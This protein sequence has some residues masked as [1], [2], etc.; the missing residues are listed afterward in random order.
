MH[1]TR[2]Y[3]LVK[4]HEIQPNTI[5]GAR[6]GGN[7]YSAVSINV[8]SMVTV[9]FASRYVIKLRPALSHGGTKAGTRVGIAGAQGNSRRV[10]GL[11][12]AVAG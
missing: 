10:L 12:G 5:T 4:T 3:M 11:S 9:V 7:H 6:L 8:L 2:Y 1:R